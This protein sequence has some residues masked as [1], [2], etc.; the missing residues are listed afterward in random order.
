LRFFGGKTGTGEID[1]LQ[2]GT[3]GQD[4]LFQIGRRADDVT[5][6]ES[7]HRILRQV[8]GFKV[9]QGG[10]KL[11]TDNSVLTQN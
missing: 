9:W 10:L 3:V 2:I 8:D 5:G 6:D 1:S 7:R 11:E 4:Q